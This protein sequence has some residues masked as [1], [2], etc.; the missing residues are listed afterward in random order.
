MLNLENL[1]L[2]LNI[3][4]ESKNNLLQLIIDKIRT[5]MQYDLQQDC[6]NKK[7]QSIALDLCVLQYN[8]IS[9]PYDISKDK[10]NISVS[11][12]EI[13]NIYKSII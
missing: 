12:S 13:D 10:G 7:Q 5:L 2:L 9:T 8:R 11:T 6:L 3:T 1:K 4:D